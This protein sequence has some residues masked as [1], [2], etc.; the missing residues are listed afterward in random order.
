M[1]WDN[2]ALSLLERT[3]D[4]SANRRIF[5]PEAFLLTDEVLVRAQKLVDGLRGGPS[6]TAQSAVTMASLPL[7]NGC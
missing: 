3:L 2:A 6:P 7:Q 1:A 5:L 4:D